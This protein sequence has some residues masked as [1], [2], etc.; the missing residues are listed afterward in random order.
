M[1]CR[2]RTGKRG[3]AAD[4]GVMAK[5]IK[6]AAG[7]FGLGSQCQSRGSFAPYVGDIDRRARTAGSKSCL[8][9]AVRCGGGRRERVL[10]VHS[11]SNLPPRPALVKGGIGFPMSKKTAL[12]SV[13]RHSVH[14]IARK[15]AG[16]LTDHCRRLARL[17]CG[18]LRR[19][20]ANAPAIRDNA[21]GWSNACGVEQ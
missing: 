14:G 18:T 2:Y 16:P 9:S 19:R 10:Q 5:L 4:A 7:G 20:R 8:L 13:S 21:A 17:G 1:C 6:F 15:P 3:G 11:L 12:R